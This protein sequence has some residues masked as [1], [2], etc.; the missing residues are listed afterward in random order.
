MKR[1]VTVFLLSALALLSFA[2]FAACDGADEKSSSEGSTKYEPDENSHLLK[3]GETVCEHCGEQLFA[4]KLEFTLSDNQKYY[5]VSGLSSASG[6]VI[7]PDYFCSRGDDTF[8]PILEIS[9]YTGDDVVSLEI[10]A[11]T[12]ECS[13]GS[14][15]ALREIRV[16]QGNK[17]YAAKDG[18]LYNKS[19]SKLVKYPGAKENSN[20]SVP[21]NVTEIAEHAFDGSERLQSVEI[22]A[23]VETLGDG[24][25][26]LCERLTAVN[27][28]QGS[29]LKTIGKSVFINCI[30]LQMIEIPATVETLGEGAFDYC[31]SLAAVEFEQKSELKSIEKNVFSECESLRTIEIPAAVELI[32]DRAFNF[33]KSLATVEFAQD[34]V[35]K[36]IG[37]SAFMGCEGLRTIE[38]PATVESINE[39]AF[40]DCLSLQA[41]KIPALI[42]EI[43][44]SAFSFC[45]AL[46]TVEFAQNSVLKTIG[47]NAFTNCRSLSVIEIPAGVET[48]GEDAFGFCDALTAV[49][50]AQNSV[51]NTIEDGAFNFCRELKQIVIPASVENM[52][53]MIFNCWDAPQRI[54]VPFAEG[55]LPAGWSAGWLNG[56]Y[57]P[58]IVEYGYTGE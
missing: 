9:G 54:C 39:Y 33:C 55:D 7:I 40:N 57:D 8:L 12:E 48:I 49:N 3:E 46:A 25:F 56:I 34:S 41:I 24:A 18:V 38:I 37:E 13:I 31:K 22:S 51:L 47:R 43:K 26:S 11:I 17:Y 53:D 35:L 28:A 4:G 5:R 50:F 29:A 2:L 21:T 14:G 36:S 44:E 45:S 58:S 10:P 23:T 1:Y 52:G 30:S 16:A 32:G 27:F 15:N 42:E 19:F 20:F 6:D